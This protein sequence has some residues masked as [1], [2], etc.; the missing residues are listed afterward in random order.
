MPKKP[1]NSL[2]KNKLSEITTSDV[3]DNLEEYTR[4][5]SANIDFNT[6]DIISVTRTDFEYT[7]TQQYAC[8]KVNTHTNRIASDT[9][10]IIQLPLHKQ[11][12]N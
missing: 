4:M 2:I 1:S 11:K 6:F 9:K 10:N 7:Y 3:L 12:L 5:M 8:R